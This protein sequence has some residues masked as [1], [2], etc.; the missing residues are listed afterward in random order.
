[1]T[2]FDQLIKGLRTLN[3]G[4]SAMSPTKKLSKW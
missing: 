3:L 2:Q 1:V 4:S